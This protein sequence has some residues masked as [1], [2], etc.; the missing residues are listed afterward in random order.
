MDISEII[1]KA[2]E[3]L[4]KS[5]GGIDVEILDTEMSRKY[6]D[7]FAPSGYLGISILV[8]S[9]VNKHRVFL[10]YQFAEDMLFGCINPLYVAESF[11]IEIIRDDIPKLEIKYKMQQR[12][13]K[14]NQ[15]NELN[16]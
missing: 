7:N 4:K 13:Q 10:K 14:L 3:V 16:N 6:P 15:I 1:L 11:I 8:N 9:G 5:F 12:K 2:V